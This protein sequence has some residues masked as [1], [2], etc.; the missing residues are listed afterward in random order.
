VLILFVAYVANRRKTLKKYWQTEYFAVTKQPYDRMRR[1]AGLNGEYSIYK[2]LSRLEGNR[3]FLFNCYLPKRD[4]TTSEIDLLL[5]HTS[6]IYVIESKNYSGW[7]FGRESQAI[8]TQRFR[9]GHKERFYNPMMQNNS[10]IIWLKRLLPE[11]PEMAFRSIVVFSDHC[12]LKT[13]LSSKNHKVVHCC[14]VFEA[15]SSTAEQNVLTNAGVNAIFH[16]LYKFSQ[17]SEITRFSHS[18]Q[19]LA[20]KEMG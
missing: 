16:K 5:L 9:N 18:T 3:K 11:V 15:V 1:N 19:V 8:W 12:S 17:V 10:H 20:D 7:I 2:S 13:D 6:G 4:G 14:D